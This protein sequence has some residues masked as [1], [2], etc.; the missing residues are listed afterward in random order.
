M[1]VSSGLSIHFCFWPRTKR[2]GT[3]HRVSFRRIL[4]SGVVAQSFPLLPHFSVKVDN[5][6]IVQCARDQGRM[7]K[8]SLP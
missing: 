8:A 1:G 3:L 6:G 2:K 7:T 5:E 4:N